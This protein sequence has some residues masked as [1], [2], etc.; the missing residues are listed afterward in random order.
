MTGWDGHALW[1]AILP[2]YVEVAVKLLAVVG[3]AA[4]G[5]WVIGWLARRLGRLL[6][7]R[8]VPRPALR[9][10]RVL[11]GAAAGYAVWLMVF[12]PGGSGLFGGGGSLFGGHGQENGTPAAATQATARRAP[13]TRATTEAERGLAVRVTVLGGARVVDGRFY[14]VEGEKEARTLGDLKQF[15]KDRKRSGVRTLELL[16]YQNSVARSHPAVRELEE[17]AQQ[18]DFTVSIPPT[19]GDIP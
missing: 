13:T 3:G 18:N 11:A 17:W 7:V 16:I 14:L 5:A 2:G 15:L 19:H 10:L 8:E 1:P 12:A 6:S 9:V 4:L